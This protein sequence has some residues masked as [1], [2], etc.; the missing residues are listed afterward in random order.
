MFNIT[1]NLDSNNPPYNITPQTQEL[2]PQF[3][4]SNVNSD[5]E[6][7]NNKNKLSIDN[8]AAIALALSFF[9]VVLYFG[10]RLFFK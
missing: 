10:V 1:M 8:I 7:S 4:V 3:S 2:K 9:A 6:R 5:L